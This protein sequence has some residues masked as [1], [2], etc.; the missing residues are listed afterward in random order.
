MPASV[1]ANSATTTPSALPR[2]AVTGPWGI[3]PALPSAAAR[4]SQ[5]G[6]TENWNVDKRDVQLKPRRTGREQVRRSPRRNNGRRPFD[7]E[8]VGRSERENRR[9][10]Q[11]KRVA[12]FLP[13]LSAQNRRVERVVQQERAAAQEPWRKR[14]AGAG[15]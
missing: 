1:R 5:S 13:R 8:R 10:G 12:S 6:F 15:K 3:W 7:R 14:Q 4:G 11:D 9:A 2:G